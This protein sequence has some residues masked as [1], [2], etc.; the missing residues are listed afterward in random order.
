MLFLVLS[1]VQIVDNDFKIL[2]VCHINRKGSCHSEYYMAC[3]KYHKMHYLII[4]ALL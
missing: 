4:K 1:A 3:E 2:H